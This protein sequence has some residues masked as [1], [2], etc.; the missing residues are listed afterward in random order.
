MA[1]MAG[2]FMLLVADIGGTHA[3]FALAETQRGQVRALQHVHKLSVRDHRTVHA[4]LTAYRQMIDQPL[5]RDASLAVAG[6]VGGETIEF[7]NSPWRFKPGDLASAFAFKRYTLINDF[8]AIGH[9]IAQLSRDRLAHVC[10]PDTGLPNTGNISILGPGTGCGVAQLLR[11]EDTYHVIETEGSHLHFGPV[12]AVDDDILRDLRK[13]HARVSAERV[14]S[15]VGLQT[16]YRVLA[17]RAGVTPEH[18][19]DVTL[20]QR[21]LAGEDE[22]AVA[23]LK[24]FCLCLGALAGDLALAHGAQAVVIAGGLGLRIGAGLSGPEFTQRFTEKGRYQSMLEA[25]PVYRLLEEEP[26][27][28]GAAA[29][30]LQRFGGP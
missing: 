8:G 9:A 21:A 24:R 13:S 29:A 25:I 3:R 30:F 26:G 16:L 19:D 17:Q 2:P 6:P 11:T 18:V 5:P 27:L 10:G 7:T 28:L 22:H 23:A 12:D 14:V 4:A 15:G 20:W 1:L